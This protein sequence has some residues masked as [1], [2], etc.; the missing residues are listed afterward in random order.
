M[1]FYQQ[2]AK[3]APAHGVCNPA[4]MAANLQGELQD[5]EQTG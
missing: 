2:A 1:A 5:Q 4:E 3:L